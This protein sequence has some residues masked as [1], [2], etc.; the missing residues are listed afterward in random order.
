M[1]WAGEG[2]RKGDRESQAVSIQSAQSLEPGSSSRT[3]RS[4]PEPK[5]TVRCLTDWATQAPIQCHFSSVIVCV[6]LFP[7]LYPFT[8]VFFLSLSQHHTVL[9]IITLRATWVA[10]S[11]EH[12]TLAQV[13]ISQFLSWN[14]TSGSL[15]SAQSLLQILCPPL[16]LPLPRSCCLSQ[17]IITIIITLQ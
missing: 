11:I 8:D 4:W 9:I 1:V 6:C 16:S 14:P 3:V 15:L 17:K 2:Q 7:A 13:M 12:P 5:S 10:L